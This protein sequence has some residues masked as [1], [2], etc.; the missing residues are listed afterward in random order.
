MSSEIPK[1]VVFD[2]DGTLLDSVPDL[3]IAADQAVRQ[4]G[5]P[6]VSECQV[7]DY[8]GNGADILI[9]RALSQSL[10]INPDLSPALL[11]EART[12]FDEFYAATGHRLSQL[13]AGVKDTLVKL[14][15]EGF[16][17]AVVTN[18]P[19]HFVPEILQQHQIADYFSD[20][21]GGDDFEKR[22]P[23]PMAL[24]WLL[25]K[26]GLK[27]KQMM[28]V[29]DSKNDIL[30]ARN[31]GCHS[32]GLTYGYNHG[33]PIADSGPDYVADNISEL[34]DIVLVSA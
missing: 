32:F 27:P 28:M 24:N 13:Y 29:G 12:Y 31:A 5:Y 15:Q 25:D 16:T 1:L 21:I 26:Y 22:K 2:L 20:V 6:G 7:R 11:K 33:E 14:H 34:L 17:L 30:A 19:S 9:G 4:L 3:A 23:D 10:E 18:K 8:V